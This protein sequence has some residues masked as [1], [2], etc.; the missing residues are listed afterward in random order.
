MV[1]AVRPA[2]SAT[3]RPCANVFAGTSTTSSLRSASCPIRSTKRGRP[4]GHRATVAGRGGPALLALSPR[5]ARLLAL[6]P[7]LA[8]L[9]ALSPRLAR[10]LALSPRLARLCELTGPNLG[11][12]GPVQEDLA[13]HDAGPSEASGEQNGRELDRV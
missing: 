11:C 3:P 1:E 7:R 10:L 13:G 2:P 8:R 5:L 4:A 6:S 12:R 9:L